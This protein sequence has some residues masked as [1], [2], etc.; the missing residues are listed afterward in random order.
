MIR[1]EEFF[2]SDSSPI[3]RPLKILSHL[4]IHSF[5]F[6]MLNASDRSDSLNL[7][8]FTYFPV[9]SL[10]FTFESRPI[11]LFES[12]F[13]FVF[14]MRFERDRKR[15]R[16]SYLQSILYIHYS[17]FKEQS[18]AQPNPLQ[19]QTPLRPLGT[20]P[21]VFNYCLKTVVLY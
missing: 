5:V 15:L 10:R 20:S 19:S 9:L 1:Q 14:S 7:Q 3:R 21:R 6:L 8:F 18:Q 2:S 12:A 17:V 11:H 13:I 4:Q 16:V